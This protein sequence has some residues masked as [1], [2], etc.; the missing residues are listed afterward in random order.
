MD[1]IVPETPMDWVD[2]DEIGRRSVL[3]GV[4]PFV[5]YHRVEGPTPPDWFFYGSE[6]EDPSDALDGSET[7]DPSNALNGSETE[8]LVKG[9]DGSETQPPS[10]GV[11]GSEILPPSPLIDGSETQAPSQPFDWSETKPPSCP[12]NWWER[13]TPSI[14]LDEIEEDM[15]AAMQPAVEPK[16]EYSDNEKAMLLIMFPLLKD[17]VGIDDECDCEIKAV[18]IDAKNVYVKLRKWELMMN[19]YLI[20]RHYDGCC[21]HAGIG[22]EIRRFSRR[23]QR[24]YIFP[25]PLLLRLDF[26]LLRHPKTKNWERISTSETEHH[27]GDRS[28]WSDGVEAFK[29]VRE[30]SELVAG[31]KWKTF[32]RRFNKAFLEDG[33]RKLREL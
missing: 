23:F 18:G 32:I 24:I 7:E 8:A 1:S 16:R 5:G 21:N 2:Y 25:A 14:G 20:L 22:L 13:E 9:F 4:P 19:V 26:P 12:V 15:A 33:E 31:L 27:D 30:W 10:E 6:T 3:H 11:Y 17:A 28:W 29:K